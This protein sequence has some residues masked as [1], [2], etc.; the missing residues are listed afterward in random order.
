M[1]YKTTLTRQLL[2]WLDNL[3]HRNKSIYWNWD[4]DM[5]LLPD[6]IIWRRSSED[7]WDQ[8][9]RLD[10]FKEGRYIKDKVKN[11]L[12]CF[13]YNYIDL[14]LKEF[15]LNR[16]KIRIL[17]NLT[18]NFSILK[19]NKGNGVVLMIRADYISSV[20]SLFIDSKFLKLI[21]DLTSTRL[22]SLQ[23]YLSTLLKRGEI[24][25]SEYNFLRPKMILQ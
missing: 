6:L 17:N 21:S 24:T 22:T 18:A 3:S 8:I 7:V 19:P 5:D 12:R 20:K 25:D 1:E 10:I 13:T 16:N 14:D 11:S 9:F 23:K 15:K 4:C 2:I